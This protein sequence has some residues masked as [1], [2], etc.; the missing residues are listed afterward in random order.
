MPFFLICFSI[1]PFH[2]SS[3]DAL[4]PRQQRSGQL[5]TS[6]LLENILRFMHAE[7]PVIWNLSIIIKFF[8]IFF[9]ISVTVNL[10]TQGICSNPC[11]RLSDSGHQPYGC[12]WH[13]TSSCFLCLIKVLLNCTILSVGHEGPRPRLSPAWQPREKWRQH[14]CFAQALLVMLKQDL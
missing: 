9:I 2:S 6:E 7:F 11:V 10:F 3:L 14:F 1:F 5:S 12:W 13:F 8:F 4:L